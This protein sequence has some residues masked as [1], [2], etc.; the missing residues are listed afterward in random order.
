VVLEFAGVAWERWQVEKRGEIAKLAA[1]TSDDE[2]GA[3]RL[4]RQVARQQEQLQ[5]N[6]RLFPIDAGADPAVLRQRY[7]D[8][9]RYAIVMAEMKVRFSADDERRVY[10]S[11]VSLLT[12]QLHVPLSVQSP[13]ADLPQRK[14]RSRYDS[15][16]ELRDWQPRY[17]VTVNW[18]KRFE[19]WIETIALT[20]AGVKAV[21]L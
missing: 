3:K 1:Q 13:L 15:P 10:G 6:S 2:E 12:A 7:P 5:S 4:A 18:G 14:Y 11:I 21:E 20:E 16:L 9:S 8:R 17:S 19:P